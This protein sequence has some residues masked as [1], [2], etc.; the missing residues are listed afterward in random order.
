MFGIMIHVLGMLSC[1]TV[2]WVGGGR[3]SNNNEV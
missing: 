2:V 1:H 3:T